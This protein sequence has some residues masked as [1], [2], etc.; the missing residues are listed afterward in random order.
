MARRF[1][2]ARRVQRSDLIQEGIAGLLFATRRYDARTGTPF[3]AYASWWARQAM[4]DVLH[5]IQ[6]GTFAREWI[7]ENRAGQENFKRMREEQ[8]GHQVEVVGRELRAQMAWIDT[9]FQE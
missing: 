8:A 1:Q 9:E 7:A 6:D 2:P 5:D 4:Q 3:W